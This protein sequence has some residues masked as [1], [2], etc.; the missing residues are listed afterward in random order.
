MNTLKK[1]GL[2]AL[3]TSLIASSAFAGDVT[4]TGSAGITLENVDN[5]DA[6]NSFSMTDQVVFAGSGELDNGMT[7]SLSLQLDGNIMDDRSVTIATPDMGTLVFAGHGGSSAMSAVDD[8]TPSAYE[9]SWGV[10]G[11]TAET[12]AGRDS[13]ENAIAGGTTDNSFFYTAPE[14]VEGLGVKASYTPSGTNRPDGTVSWN[15]EYTGIEGLTLGYAQDDNGLSG[16]SQ[17]EYETAYV[18]YAFGS[19]TVGMQDG[20]QDQQGATTSD[21]EYSAIGISY[22]VSDDLSVSYNS[23]ER[24]FGDGDADQEA[25][26]MQL[27]YTT[28]GVT[29]SAALAEVKN[30]GGSTNAQDDIEGF[31]IDVS[32][33]F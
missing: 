33:A 21:D 7:V 26:A 6:G 25:E 24:D 1:V 16:T 9:E 27:S 32:F 31:E 18:K 19:F 30:V 13:M 11:S 12:T 28:G 2:T 14:M 23:S 8:V 15:L 22:Q 4:V 20:S 17:I 3:G 10:I 5:T 29:V